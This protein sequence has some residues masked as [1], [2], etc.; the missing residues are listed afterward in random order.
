MKMIVVQSIEL[1]PLSEFSPVLLYRAITALEGAEPSYLLES[2]EGIPRVARFSIIGF[3][4]AVVISVKSSHLNMKFYDDALRKSEFE[5]CFE[6][7]R[8][9]SVIKSFMERMNAVVI[10]SSYVR[11]RLNARCS[12]IAQ[13]G[14]AAATSASCDSS[15]IPFLGGFVGY[16]AYDF[17][18]YF[19]DLDDS[20]VD[21]L[22]HPDFSFILTRKNILFDHK[23]RKTFILSNK[24][25]PMDNIS[26]IRDA[27]YEADAEITETMTTL[28]DLDIKEIE[29][30]I[31]EEKKK[32]IKRAEA[33]ID[34]T[35][36]MSEEVFKR[37]VKKAK[38]Y[39]R[40][41]DIFQV[42]LSQR[43]ETDFKGDELQFYMRLSELNPSPYMYFLDFGTRK[44]VG[45]SPEMLVKVDAAFQWISS[46]SSA[47]SASSASSSSSASS[48]S[49]YSSSYSSLSDDRCDLRLEIGADAID[50]DD[51]ALSGAH[52]QFRPALGGRNV[53]SCPIAGTRPRGSTEH[54]DRMLELEMLNDE[55][56]R[57][58]HIMLVDLARNDIGKVSKFGTV[59]VPRFMYVEKF[60]HVQHIV[61]DVEGIL[62][63]DAD[64]FDA[65]EATFPAGTV[66]GA[67]KVRAMEII[68]ELEPTRRG[69]YAGCVG[70]FSFNRAAD[71]AITI[72]TAVFEGG[73]MYVQAGAGIVADSVPEREY[74]ETL[75]KCAAILA[76]L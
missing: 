7:E 3:D 59:R 76:C 44:V 27:I 37:I 40:A 1:M 62:R 36:N 47:S 52:R 38:E 21:D 71:T 63:D 31:G 2:R 41:G 73:K 23:E 33:G 18:R 64:E 56:E 42:V 69:I 8:P 6:P 14:I 26:G 12:S 32:K 58:E 75:N 54:E 5:R 20:T 66:S 17:V 46:S 24:F 35:A 53:R 45:A 49:S 39:I 70:Y 25:I 48:A 67:P 22:G 68:E 13:G 10:T 55:K 15:E 30:E 51:I 28:N 61:S 16:I 57:A 9:L 60:S 65:L 74:M 29:K 50:A 72:R 19:V 43:I 11:K 34:F 4:P